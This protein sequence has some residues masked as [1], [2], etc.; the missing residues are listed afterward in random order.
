MV[1]AI[2]GKFILFGFFFFYTVKTSGQSFE[3]SSAKRK[4]SILKVKIRNTTDSVIRVPVFHLRETAKEKCGINYFSYKGD[5]LLLVFDVN[6]PECLRGS[7]GKLRDEN[8]I[9]SIRYADKLLQPGKSYRQILKTD[10]YFKFINLVY[11]DRAV[12]FV[13]K[14]L[15][16]GILIYLAEM[17]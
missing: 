8:E 2:T 15:G 11:G 5:T 14:E 7:A 3:I 6:A 16:Y 10:G 17:G 9:F 12:F 4:G 1:K 13:L